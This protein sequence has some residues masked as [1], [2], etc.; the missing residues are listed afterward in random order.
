[1]NSP[2]IAIIG[3]GEAG[4]QLAL[5]LQ[6]SDIKVTLYSD[7]SAAEV[8]EGEITSTQCMFAS[9]LTAQKDLSLDCQQLSGVKITGMSFEQTGAGTGFA[10]EFDHP[11]QSID[12]RLKV[13]DWITQFTQRGGDFRIEKVGVRLLEQITSRY[14]LVIVATGKAELSQIFPVDRAR[15]PYDRPQRVVAATYLDRPLPADDEANHIRFHHKPESGEFFTFPGLTHGKECQMLVFEAVPGSELDVWD[16]VSDPDEHLQRTRD[17][18]R[19]HFPDEFARLGECELS[20]RGATLRGRITPT[21]KHPVGTLPSGATVMGIGDAVILNDPITGQGSNNA[22]LAAAHCTDAI[23]RRIRSG[24]M[25]DDEWKQQTFEGYWRSWGKWS[26]TWTNSL[27]G[28]LR[29]HQLELFSAAATHPSLA[30]SLVA[31]FDDPRT[32]FPWWSDVSEAHAFIEASARAESA[33]FDLRDFRTALGQF[34]TGVTVITTRTAD[35]RKVGMTANSFTSVSMD[36]PLV[37][38][39][40][41]KHVPSLAD[42]ESST[43]FAINV[44]AS[45]QHALSRQFATPAPDKFAGVEII[46]GAAGL[47]VLAGTVASFQCRTV[48]RHDAGDHVIYIGEVEQYAHDRAEPLVFHSGAYRETADHP[49]VS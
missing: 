24:A 26:T 49:A 9:A 44:L 13:S 14:D 34:A 3:A 6:N 2:H 42:F 46:E 16:D 35:G 21:V 15:S 30:A 19:Q 47:P 5:G 10:A 36:P 43:H 1:M 33:E 31:G 25:F 23:I 8:A 40:P 27:L 37:L 20:D 12:Q 29:N 39:C 48:A 11:A 22:A 17:V 18:L 4:A 32:L 28:G 45:D 41:G 38:W 7:Q